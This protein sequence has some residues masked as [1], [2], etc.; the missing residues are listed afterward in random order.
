MSTK[1]TNRVRY[2]FI[3]KLTIATSPFTGECDFGPKIG[4][5]LLVVLGTRSC[6]E[7]TSHEE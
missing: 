5:S 4:S 3:F 7:W 1:T 2:D 6:G